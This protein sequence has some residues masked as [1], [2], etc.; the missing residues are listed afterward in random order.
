MYSL[1][2]K[3]IILVAVFI[4]LQTPAVH[5]MLLLRGPDLQATIV[6]FSGRAGLK[7]IDSKNRTSPGVLSIHPFA[8]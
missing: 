8:Y 7:K 6:G 3:E 5:L 1:S 2:E 4:P